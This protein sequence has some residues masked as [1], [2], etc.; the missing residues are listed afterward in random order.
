MRHKSL[1]RSRRI[2]LRRVVECAPLAAAPSLSHALPQSSYPTQSTQTS[3]PRPAHIAE[4]S[5]RPRFFDASEWAFLLAACERLIPADQ[6]GPGAVQVGVPQYIDQQMG[7]PWAEGAIWYMQEPFFETIP[8]LGYQTNLTP[9]EQ[10]RIGIKTTNNLCIQIFGLEFAA[11][12]E[13]QQD[14]ILGQLENGAITSP[15]LSLQ[16]FFKQFLLPNT[17][18]GFFCD[19]M[20]GGNKNMEGWQMIRHPGAR[21]DYLDFVAIASPYPF[22]PVSIYGA[23]SK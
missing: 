13:D 17:I 12:R 21:A 1:C 7:T 16:D 11:L 23:S 8:E 14:H 9:Q 18:E 2:F 6:I 4:A 20:Y 3:R 5:Y 15:L 19:P 10:Y 22:G